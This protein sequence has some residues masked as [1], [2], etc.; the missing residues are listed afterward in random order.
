MR[1]FALAFSFLISG[2]ALANHH[3]GCVEKIRKDLTSIQ[4]DTKKLHKVRFISNY[5]NKKQIEKLKSKETF[6]SGLLKGEKKAFKR[7]SDLMCGIF[8]YKI[9]GE[10]NYNFTL[11]NRKGDCEKLALGLKLSCKY[12]KDAHNYDNFIEYSMSEYY[13]C[14]ET[15]AGR[16][17]S[18][19]LK[20]WP[21][22]G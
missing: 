10:G 21:K 22:C 20:R 17:D 19:C 5:L 2:L 4:K 15:K 11:G 9:V 18:R 16:K 8:K 6:Y 13:F 3:L 12:N 14:C 7:A 1:Y